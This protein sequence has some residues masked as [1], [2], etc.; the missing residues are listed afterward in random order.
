MAVM[1]KDGSRHHSAS[2]ARLHDDLAASKGPATA[3]PAGKA[4]GADPAAAA[5]EPALAQDHPHLPGPHQIPTETPVADHVGKHGLATHA[6]VA[7]GEGPEG[8]VH[9]TTHHGG[10]GKNMHHTKH[11]TMAAAHEHMG[12]AMGSE[13]GETQDHEDYETPDTESSEKDRSAKGGI[14]GLSEED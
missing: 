6:F 11:D 12:Q 14:P 3:K 1:A 9:V 5:K 13:G 8:E 4:P 10:L 7:R 2:R